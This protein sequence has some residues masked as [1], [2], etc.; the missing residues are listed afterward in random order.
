MRP[1]LKWPGG[2]YRLTDRIRPILAPGA[3]LIE[4]FTGSG[5]VFLNTVYGEYL[6]ADS[7]ADLI[8]LYQRLVTG[9]ADF[10]AYCHGLFLPGN[11]NDQVYY[12]LRD[13]FNSSGD[14][15][16]KS[17]LFLYLNRH[18]YNGLIRYNSKGEFNTPFGRYVKP[19]FPEREMRHFINAAEKATFLHASFTESMPLA[20]RG[21]I[22]YCDPPYAPLSG[23]AYF[24]DY[25]TGGFKWRHQVQLVELARRLADRGIQVVISNHD[26]REIREL[27]KNAKASIIKFQVRR[28]ISRDINNRRKVGE[29]L[30]VFA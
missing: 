12:R 23:T 11:N 1:F 27:Y 16:R 25:Y 28:Y 22:V 3:R 8:N 14:V 5:A 13:E 21:D 9:G 15:H 30:A 4:P 7:N 19:Y 2:K 17:A 6:L 29:L 26:T 20:Q 18:C 24:A 10:I